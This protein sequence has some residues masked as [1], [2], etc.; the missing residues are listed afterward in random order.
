M[1][2]LVLMKVLKNVAV[3]SIKKEEFEIGLNKS[4]SSFPVPFKLVGLAFTF[5][6]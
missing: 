5:R 2:A 4:Q 6:D 3:A 1:K